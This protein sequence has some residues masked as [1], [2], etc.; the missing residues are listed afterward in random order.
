VWDFDEVGFAAS[1]SDSV[2]DA[3]EDDAVLDSV[4]ELDESLGSSSP[5]RLA[6]AA[7]CEECAKGAGKPPPVEASATPPV[8]AS[9]MP[10]AAT[11]LTALIL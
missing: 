4:E 3:A 8:A 11:S 10:P 5:C 7:A 9:A 1:A 6:D 2:P